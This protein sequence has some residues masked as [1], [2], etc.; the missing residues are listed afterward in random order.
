M[1]DRIDE[2]RARELLA[3]NAA[4][5]AVDEQARARLWAALETERYLPF[6]NELAAHFDFGEAAMRALLATLADPAAWTRGEPPV[7][8]YVD[9]T[10]GARLLP[11]RAGFVRLAAGARI[12]RHRHRDRELTMVLEGVLVDDG[13]RSYRPGDVIEMAVGSVHALAVPEDQEAVVALLHGRI[14][15]LAG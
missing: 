12:A 4:P 15:A 2:A 6:C 8:R 7:Q 3:E 5:M 10:P 14:E 9:F 11:L 1:A 13:G